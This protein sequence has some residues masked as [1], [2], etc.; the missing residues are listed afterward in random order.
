MTAPNQRVLKLASNYS[1]PFACILAYRWLE[2]KRRMHNAGGPSLPDKNDLRVIA[3]TKDYPP[4]TS[5]FQA[6]MVLGLGTIMV[7]SRD[8]PQMVPFGAESAKW[9]FIPL[10]AV[11]VLTFAVMFFQLWWEKRVGQTLDIVLII[12]VNLALVA[13]FVVVL[14]SPEA[15]YA[16][17]H[18][19]NLATLSPQCAYQLQ[20]IWY[21]LLWD[22]SPALTFALTSPALQEI[23]RNGDD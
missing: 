11:L 23:L 2:A 22:L 17:C 12:S 10:A 16:N 1:A 4:S 15:I 3:T 18:S 6:L 14:L 20:S 13:A 5:A 21:W 19:A 8:Y 9:V 7:L